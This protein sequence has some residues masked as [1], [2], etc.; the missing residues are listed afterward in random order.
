MASI[1]LTR[2]I[3]RERRKLPKRDPVKAR[4]DARVAALQDQIKDSTQKALWA[5]QFVWDQ[6]T[7]TEKFTGEDSGVRDHKG[8]QPH[9]T[10]EMNRLYDQLQEQ[11]WMLTPAQ[12]DQ[13][14]KAMQSYARQILRLTGRIR[15]PYEQEERR[16][17]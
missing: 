4:D 9:R 11:G 3:P 12:C 6:Q 17:A 13:L 5:F 2:K 7:E 14:R 16:S 1:S 10:A 8:F 15:N